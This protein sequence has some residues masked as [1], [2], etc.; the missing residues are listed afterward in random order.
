MIPAKSRP[1]DNGTQPARAR[2]CATGRCRHRRVWTAHRGQGAGDGG[3]PVESIER[4]L[5]YLTDI[6]RSPK[7]IYIDAHRGEFGV[8]PNVQIIRA[9]PSKEIIG[10]DDICKR[11]SPLGEKRSDQ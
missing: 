2:L 4:Y 10:Q 5:A 1:P 8:E 9:E 6:E 3:V 11:T 7:M